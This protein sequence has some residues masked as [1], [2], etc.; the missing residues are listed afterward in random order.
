M[1]VSNTYYGA[2]KVNDILAGKK[3]IFFIGIG[4]VSMSSLAI[5]AKNLG[6]SVGGSDRAMS[7]S[8]MRLTSNG[9]RVCIGHRAENIRGYDIAVYTVAISDENPEYNEARRMGIPCVSRADFLGAL[10]YGFENRIGICGMHGKSSVTAMVASI[11]SRS[12]DPTVISGAS[13]SGSDE[14]CRLGG[15]RDFIFEACEYQDSFLSFY[16]STAVVLNIELDHTD[17]FVSLDQIR[18]SFSRFISIASG[19][20]LVYNLDDENVRSI[21][22]SFDGRRISF[23]VENSDADVYASDITYDRGMPRFTV[24]SGD[25]RLFEVSL[26]V[27]GEHNISNALAAAATALAHSLPYEDIVAGLGEFSGAKR[28]LTYKGSLH[29][30]EIYD[31]YAHH[32]TEIDAAVNALRPRCKG[33]LWGVLQPHTYSRTKELYIEFS[34]ALARF[35]RV[36]LLDIYAARETDTL[37]VSSKQLAQS[38]GEHAIYAP[39][40]RAA[41]EILTEELGAKDIAVIMGAGDNERVFDHLMLD[42]KPRK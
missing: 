38:V 16:P 40:F 17:Y 35:D 39:S 42:A 34:R 28:R 37:G 36:I 33:K 19:G 8:T 20:I 24:C 30:A 41:A 25:K 27:L 13:L 14:C 29:R 22:D 26:G 18:D 7:A 15:D 2:A 12:L 31:D 1:A 9:I 10:M 23:S 6:F 5:A 4:G 11:F 21:C 32:P 3:S